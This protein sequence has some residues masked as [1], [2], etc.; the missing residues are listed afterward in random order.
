MK[1]KKIH[2]GIITIGII[3]TAISIFHTNLWFDESYSV[4]I[5]KHSFKDIYTIGSADVHPVLY[6]WI[7]HII[8]LILGNN[9]IAYRIFSVI[10]I[11]I[12]GIIGYTHIKKDFGEKA[13]IIFS[14]LAFFWPANIVYAGEIRMYTMAMLEVTIMCIYAYRIYKNRDSHQNEANANSKSCLKNWTIFA[15]FSLASAY[16]HY[17]S[18]MAAG[19]VN[20]MLFIV[21]TKDTIKQKKITYNIKAFAISAITQMI[22]YIP[23]LI[24]ILPQLGQKTG[25][26]IQVKF[27]DTI[28]EMLTF[29]FAGNLGGA[30]YIKNWI[31][32]ALEIILLS[33]IIYIN[34]KNKEKT[35][36]SKIAIAIWLSIVIGAC[37][38][39][40]IKGT[41]LIYARY[42]FCVMGLLIFFI[43]NTMAQSKNQKIN[44]AIC[45]ICI[46]LSINVTIT[47]SQENYGKTN[48]E[49]QKYIESTLKKDDIIISATAGSGFVIASKHPENEFYFYDIEKWNVEKAYKAYGN[50]VTEL[51]FLD[52][53]KGRIWIINQN[54][55]IYDT[56]KEKYNIELIEQKKFDTEYKGYQYDITI[57]EKK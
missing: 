4:A 43:S 49:V 21:F 47:I 5:A 45:T 26:W 8:N 44:I 6:Y 48:K 32:I 11:D 3:F 34:I 39:S 53:I 56:L 10:C 15:I 29:Q 36:P 37:V 17:Y 27:P 14:S 35:K 46:M 30:E 31:V 42:M 2:I 9:I 13:G 52:N 50:T 22:L 7:L 25:F 55:K 19:I 51:D 41:P 57:I 1:N 40:V 20:L 38:I 28:I 16:T 24:I 33:Y 18:L 23:W 12:L 54:E